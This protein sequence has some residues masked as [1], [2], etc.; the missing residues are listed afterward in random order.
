MHPGTAFSDELQ[1]VC[2]GGSGSRRRKR[3]FIRP[4]CCLRLRGA[5]RELYR[6]ICYRRRGENVLIFITTT[7]TTTTTSTTVENNMTFPITILKRIIIEKRILNSRE[8]HRRRSPE[9]RIVWIWEK[10]QMRDVKNIDF[11]V[12]SDNFALGFLNSWA[13]EVDFSGPLTHIKR[14][15]VDDLSGF[16]EIEKS[17]L[18]KCLVI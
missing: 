2:R 12:C 4:C 1:L 13:V 8:I 9:F 14:L 16:F 7:T 3:C 10:C 15:L 11:A 5:R 18:Q 17:L 6:K